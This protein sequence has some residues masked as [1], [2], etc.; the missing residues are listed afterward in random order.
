MC[1]LAMSFEKKT[2][3][4]TLPFFSNT[5]SLP[6][7]IGFILKQDDPSID[8]KKNSDLFERTTKHWMI[9]HHLAKGKKKPP[10]H[11]HTYTQQAKKVANQLSP[12]SCNFF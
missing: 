1:P 4:Q 5:R 10:P 3:I 9:K 11:T 12:N 8:A 6:N 2:S 7:C